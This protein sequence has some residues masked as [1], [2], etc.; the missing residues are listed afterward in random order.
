MHRLVLLSGNKFKGNILEPAYKKNFH[1]RVDPNFVNAVD[2]PQEDTEDITAILDEV[3][4]E[5]GDLTPTY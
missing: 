1:I 4:E 5:V 3:K 2:I